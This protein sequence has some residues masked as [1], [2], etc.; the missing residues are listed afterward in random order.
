MPR[1]QEIASRMLRLAVSPEKSRAMMMM[2]MM[3]MM[4]GLETITTSTVGRLGVG[5]A[6]GSNGCLLRGHHGHV[7]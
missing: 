6:E 4:M 7:V 3:M 1:S 2:M 5:K